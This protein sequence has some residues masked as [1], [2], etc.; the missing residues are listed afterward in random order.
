MKYLIYAIFLTVIFGV[1]ISLAHIFNIKPL[2]PNLIFLVL[3]NFATSRTSYEFFFVATFCG[4]MLDLYSRAVPGSFTVPFLLVSYATHL[5]VSWFAVLEINWEFLLAA[6]AGGLLS[7]YC[8]IW[9]YCNAVFRLHL[10]GPVQTFYFGWQSYFREM[11]VDMLL[12]LP[13]YSA[14]DWFKARIESAL[15]RQNI[16]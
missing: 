15:L 10:D 9:L 13:V 1:N 7:V 2:V 12:V 4:L 6:A 16:K 3:L 14:V 11:A 8:L 5:L